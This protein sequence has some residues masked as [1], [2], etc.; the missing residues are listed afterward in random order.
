M[1][2]AAA[3]DVATFFLG[4]RIRAVR[5]RNVLHRGW[6][7]APPALSVAVAYAERMPHLH[8]PGVMQHLCVVACRLSTVACRCRVVVA[9]VVSVAAAAAE[10]VVVISCC[11]CQLSTAVCRWSLLCSTVATV[12]F[13]YFEQLS[14]QVNQGILMHSQFRVQRERERGRKRGSYLDKIII[15]A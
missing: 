15:V 6:L 13:T 7:A 2:T 8:L 10:V 4:I 11:S 14:R 9:A 1:P 12:A 5:L 3:Q